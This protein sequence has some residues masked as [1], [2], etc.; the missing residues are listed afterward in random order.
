MSVS[1]RALELGNRD[2]G[3]VE[4]VLVARQRQEILLVL[5]KGFLASLVLAFLIRLQLV[6]APPGKCISKFLQISNVS[7]YITLFRYHAY[8]KSDIK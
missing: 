7:N 4:L 1:S 3:I 5:D 8:L 2:I 6:S